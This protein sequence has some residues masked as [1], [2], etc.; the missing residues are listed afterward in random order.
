MDRKKA[1]G[2]YLKCFHLHRVEFQIFCQE[3][4]SLG[5]WGGSEKRNNENLSFETFEKVWG[6]H[7][8]FIIMRHSVT[9]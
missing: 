8:L 4:V 5:Q 1:K 2:V 3:E 7:V 6:T 9:V